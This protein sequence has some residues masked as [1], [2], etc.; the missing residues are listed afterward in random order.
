ML[1]ERIREDKKMAGERKEERAK[2][3]WFLKK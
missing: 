2:E 3:K 1:G